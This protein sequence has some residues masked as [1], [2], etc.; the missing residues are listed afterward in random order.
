MARARLKENGYQNPRSAC[1]RHEEDG[2]EDRDQRANSEHML[3][4][5]LRQDDQQCKTPKPSLAKRVRGA[6]GDWCFSACNPGRGQNQIASS[7]NF[8]Q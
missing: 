5:P 8:S 1:A 3:R 2:Y 6:G 4:S 7:L